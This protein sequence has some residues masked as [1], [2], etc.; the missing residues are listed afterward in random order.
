MC[1]WPLWH[2][3]FKF[4]HFQN[5]ICNDLSHHLATCTCDIVS[6][7]ILLPDNVLLKLKKIKKQQQ[8]Q[9][10]KTGKCPTT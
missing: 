1:F 8:Q 4:W 6:Y 7:Y 5:G 9:Q 2:L 3:V 10:K